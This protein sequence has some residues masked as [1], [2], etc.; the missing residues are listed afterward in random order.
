MRKLLSI[1]PIDPIMVRDGRPFTI[2]P[3]IRAHT[4]NDVTPSTVTGAIRTLLGKRLAAATGVEKIAHYAKVPV[5]GPLYEWRG[6]LYFPMPQ[7]VELHE[8]QKVEK[9]RFVKPTQPSDSGQ[10]FW[11]V[12]KEGLLNG[13]DLLWPPIGAGQAKTSLVKPSYVSASWMKRWLCGELDSKAWAAALREW[14]VSKEK[15]HSQ[16]EGDIPFLAAWS[17]EVRTHTEIDKSTYSARKEH[18][19]STEALA[20]PPDVTMQVSLEMPQEESG[21][22]DPIDLL[23]PLG[24]KRR[25][26]HFSEMKEDSQW[27]CPPEIITALDGKKYVKMVLV[28][29]AYFRKGWLPGWL[30]EE[31]ETKDNSLGVRLKLRWAC[32]PRWQPISGWA[33]SSDKSKEGLN[34]KAVRRMVPAGSVYFFEVIDG[35]NPRVLAEQSWLQSVS[36]TNRR[37]EAFDKED[38][39]GLAV[40]G[41]WDCSAK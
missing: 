6:S 21:D 12:G 4:L 27:N 26:A 36:D 23:H 17:K 24:G 16:V 8:E 7:D 14:R 3:G 15:Q 19:F 5:R 25:L 1:R 39:Y 20:L 30:N 13:V 37:K 22:T 34:E 29:P 35:G 28:T 2:T 32:I 40:W 9:V 33:Y 41:V 11:G 31:L 18:L 38:G 10:G